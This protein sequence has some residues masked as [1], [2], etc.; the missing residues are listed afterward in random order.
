MAGRQGTGLDKNFNHSSPTM[1]S[2]YM[3]CFDAEK[4]ILDELQGELTVAR[5]SELRIKLK[6]I[7]ILGHLLTHGPSDASKTHIMQAVLSS[8]R[9]GEAGNG[10]RPSVEVVTADVD[11]LV[12]LGEYYDKYLLR[13]FS[14]IG[15]RTPQPSRHPSRPSFE[16]H[17]ESI[18]E[19]LLKNPSNHRQAKEL[20]LIRDGY[21]DM[22]SGRM[23]DN[24]HIEVYFPEHGANFPGGSAATE[25]AHIFP[26]S[27]NRGVEENQTR[28]DAAARFWTIMEK[29][30]YP[31]IR[32]ELEGEKIN[33]LTNILTLGLDAHHM[34]DAFG[35]WFEATDTP[36]S[37]L[38]CCAPGYHLPD[39]RWLQSD[40]PI[41]TF[42]I[43]GDVDSSLN[44]VLPNPSYLQIHAAVCKVS[45]MS[46]AAGY[47]N[48]ARHDMDEGGGSTINAFA[49]ALATR[50]E[51]FGGVYSVPLSPV[52]DPI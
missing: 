10:S 20:A 47:Y 43:Y 50:L 38:V 46:A 19:L 35:L 29:F 6:N 30:G 48:R 15:Y 40:K 52:V 42:Q 51:G 1:N 18:K 32:K 23:D 45:H 36:H 37:Y 41:I 14:H 8:G 3:M 7:R 27:I 17:V 49:E 13:P 2:A 25:C 34:F 21:M 12:P 16:V 26:R 11:K 33:S 44:I 31:E 22:I 9:Q 39:H 28:R 4:H 5:K 24:Y